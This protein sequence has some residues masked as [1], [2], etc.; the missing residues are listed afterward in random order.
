MIDMKRNIF[1]I[2]AILF[3]FL[4][5]FADASIHYLIYAESEFEFIPNDFN[6]LW[7]RVVIIILVILFGAFADF[8]SRKM[9]TRE[10]QI[11]ALHIYQSTLFATHHI[12]NNLLN[13]MQLFKIEA[14]KSADFDKGI[15]EF[16]DVATEEASRLIDK[17]SSIQEITEDNIKESVRPRWLAQTS[18]DLISAMFKE[19]L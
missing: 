7:M 12:L 8:H 14:S 11:E 18:T 6:E 5:W 17:L 3:A 9:I 13:Q 2:V 15:L 1:S 16:Y 19:N 4:F 10:K